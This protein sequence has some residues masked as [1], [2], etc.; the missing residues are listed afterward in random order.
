MSHNWAMLWF[1]PLLACSGPWR[2][3][4]VRSAIA[5]LV[6]VV[7]LLGAALAATA[8]DWPT[9]L[10]DPE[11]TA[12]SWDEAP[13]DHLVRRDAGRCGLRGRRRFLLVRPRRRDGGDPVARVHGR[14]QLQLGPLQLVQSPPLQRLCLHR[15]GQ[16]RRLP[17]GPGPVAAG[18]SGHPPDRAYV[19][20]R[21]HRPDR[22][23][24]L[25][26]A[27]HR[28][29]DGDDLRDDGHAAHHP[30]PTARQCHRRPGRGH[31]GRQG[32]LARSD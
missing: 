24:H 6:A 31:T 10:H 5:R 14:E 17:P 32:Q 7:A 19:R 1:H 11:R 4:R 13:G 26:V 8:G 30:R 16:L 15:R 2:Q 12:T 9:Y 25:D 28:P 27:Q 22:R 29:G 21:A 23:R 18:R 3:S 20:R